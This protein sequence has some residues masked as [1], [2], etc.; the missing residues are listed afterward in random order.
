[1]FQVKAKGFENLPP[2]GK[3]IIAA[4]HS[5][6]L[7]PIVISVVIPRRIKWIIQKPVYHL[8]W[9]KWVFVLTKMIPENGA[10]EKSL[11]SL[12]NGEMLGVFPEGGRSRDGGLRAG[13]EGVAILALKTAAPVI[14][15]AIHGA[16][17]AYSP[18]AIFPKPY[19]VKILIGRPIK[20]DAIEMPDRTAIISVLNIIM[21]AINSLME[22]KV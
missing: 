5:S 21:S 11:Y 12:K 9:L 17:E 22:E 2:N 13:H 20:F 8:W 19:P 1:M 6:Y 3:A 18:T 10:I 16:F 7:D 15:C 14:P 4:N